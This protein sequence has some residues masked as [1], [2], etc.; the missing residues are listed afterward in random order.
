VAP[1]NPNPAG[2]DGSKN[3]TESK[4]AL[5]ADAASAADGLPADS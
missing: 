5:E 2:N 1:K 4:M 3:K